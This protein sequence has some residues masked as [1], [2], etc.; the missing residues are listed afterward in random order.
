MLNFKANKGD[1]DD[2]DGNNEDDDDNDGGGD[3]DDDVDYDDNDNDEKLKALYGEDWAQKSS[4]QLMEPKYYKE[5]PEFLQ[6]LPK[7]I[8]RKTAKELSEELVKYT[9]T[10]TNPGGDKTF[11]SSYWP[12]VKCVTVRVPQNQLLQHVTLVDL[13]GNGDR[14]KS[15]DTMW[16]QI[17]RNCSTVWIVSEINR[18]A[19][20]KECWE[21]LTSANSLL[22]NGGE[23]H[24]IHFICTKSDQF[25]DVDEWSTDAIRR[26][27]LNRNEK[28]KESMRKEFKKLK[29][30]NH[31]SFEVFTVSSK[32]FQNRKHLSLEETEIPKL[33]DFLQNLNDKHSETL[34]YVSGA[35]GILSL[36]QGS[37]LRDVAG[38]SKDVCQELDENIR[39]QLVS[40]KEAMKA[41][42]EAF[43][44]KLS[45]GVEKS[46]RS[47]ENRLKFFINP[48]KKR[49]GGFHRVLKCV[50]ENDGI[51]K[52]QKKKEINLNM[53]LSSFLTECIDE[54]FRKTFPNE[55]KCG[56]FN[57]AIDKFS[58]GTENLKKKYKDVEL[59]LIFLKT[60]EEKMKTE[61]N[62][63]IRDRKK[64]IYC[65]L[66]ETIANAMKECYENAAKFSGKDVLKNMIGTITNHVETLQDTM[67]EEAKK[68]MFFQL[69]I[70]T[71][72]IPGY[73][74]GNL[75]TSIK[76][77]LRT[78]Y[79]SSPDVT[80]EL[81][82]VQRLYNEL[83]MAS[84]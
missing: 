84:N 58:L 72:G 31:F 39:N 38:K 21:I 49:R 65:R 1:D 64:K 12:L 75:K 50:V 57:G 3:G 62:K 60:V 51:Y 61:L 13:P 35:R 26:F 11:R 24:Y 59:Q 44:K 45:E 36:I 52:P 37:C 18:A 79:Q 2:D 43:E 53:K 29:K 74:E 8:T 77:S 83:K 4:E 10:D 22:G 47:W 9:R 73:L 41:A 42:E 70:L 82:E 33:Q 34:N 6:T 32:W 23:C 30:M 48:P 40:V 5:I 15:R 71:K 17:I 54:E 66:T 27:V 7:K 63:I 14:N 20:E 68:A 19:A 16:K 28:A 69:Q 55:T 46:K 81:G 67:F 25:D 56:P 80:T 76:L 78:N